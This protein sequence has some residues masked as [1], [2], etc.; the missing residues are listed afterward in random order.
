MN[1][2]GGICSED[3]YPYVSGESEAS[4]ECKTDCLKDSHTIPKSFTEVERSCDACLVAAIA[5]QPVAVAIEADHRE[6]QLYKS[7]VFTA[8]CGSNLDHGVLAV[9]YGET[10]DGVKYYKVNYLTMPCNS[11]YLLILFQVKN[12]WGAAWGMDGYILL[13]RGG[14]SDHEQTRGKCGILLGP[15]LY[16][17]L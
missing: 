13:E 16:P 6:F 2:S 14:S 8:K 7:G 4:G 17:N 1:I 12:S 15:P 11:F 5:K 9:G 3:D 10:D